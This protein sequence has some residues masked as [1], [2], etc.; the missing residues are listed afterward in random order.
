[1][2]IAKCLRFSASVV[3]RSCRNG[4]ANASTRGTRLSALENR[5]PAEVVVTDQGKKLLAVWSDESG[6]APSS[7]HA[8]WLRH[9][10]QCHRCLSE[11]KQLLIQSHELDPH[12]KIAD[13]E[14]TG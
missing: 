3:Q 10:C 11:Y 13:V 7:Y 14:L 6:A 1:M 2:S 8:V 9:N 5:T 12:V 4:L